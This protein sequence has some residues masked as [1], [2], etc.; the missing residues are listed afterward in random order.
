MDF[1][2][3][4]SQ[5][6]TNTLQES[7]LSERPPFA[8]VDDN[9]DSQ[10]EY[11]SY[12]GQSA[13][14]SQMASPRINQQSKQ[15]LTPLSSRLGQMNQ[16]QD[17]SAL[18]SALGQNLNNSLESYMASSGK[19]NDRLNMYNTLISDTSRANDDM[20]D[21]HHFGSGSG[22]IQNAGE[23]YQDSMF[24]YLYI[25]SL[26]A[27]LFSMAIQFQYISMPQFGTYASLDFVSIGIGLGWIFL[28]WRFPQTL[29]WGTILTVPAGLLF[30]GSFCWVALPYDAWYTYVISAGSFISSFIVIY[31][32]KS[33]QDSIHNSSKLVQLSCQ[34]L[35]E[36]PQMILLSILILAAYVAFSSAYALLLYGSIGQIES[37]EILKVIGYVGVFLWSSSIF[38]YVEQ[39]TISGIVADWYFHRND[40][41]HSA[42]SSAMRSFQ[43]SVSWNFGS[44]CLAALIVS[45]VQMVRVVLRTM[46]Y[47]FEKVTVLSSLLTY[48]MY[49]EKAVDGINSY[50]IVYM[51]YSGMSFMEASR[52]CLDLFRERVLNGMI[53]DLLTKLILQFGPVILSLL[54]Y[55]ISRQAMS[56]EQ[57]ASSYTLMSLLTPFFMI[58]YFMHLLTCVMDS[59]YVCYAIS[60]DLPDGADYCPVS[61]Q[62]FHDS[63]KYGIQLKLQQ[64]SIPQ[65]A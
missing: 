51:A 48:T 34:V 18:S 42:A 53:I 59:L 49:M 61:Y 27:A 41:H 14:N 65:N 22:L 57:K 31:L 55:F 4:N 33:K 40:S 37:A 43:R 50:A 47:W 8:V 62:I 11:V 7:L 56:Y 36:C 1:H 23:Y 26:A 38:L 5:L 35:V 64:K 3:E 44:L 17:S 12:N 32:I 46:R 10:S 16:H 30:T 52:S 13:L 20:E 58:K 39:C 29:L 28:L 54:T 21:G 2:R 9:D 25:F 15:Y 24:K 63:S 45:F 6:N 60:L 19:G